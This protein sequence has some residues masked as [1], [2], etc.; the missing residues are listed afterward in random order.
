MNGQADHEAFARLILAIEP[1]LD[2]VVIIGGWAHR[3]YRLHPGAQVL[4][5]APL[6]TLDTD[7]ALPTKLAAAGQEVRERLFGRGFSEERLGG[8]NPPATHYVLGEVKSGFFAEFLTPLTGSAYQ[9][10][11][12]PKTTKRLGGVVAQRL[13]YLEILLAAP[14]RVDLDPSKGFPLPGQRT[15]QV[16]NPAA[17]LAHKIL[18]HKK[19]FS[20]KSAKDILYIHDTL[21]TFGGKLNDLHREWQGQ[22]RPLLH[23][24][25]VHKV[26]RGVRGLFGQ[27]N[28]SVR[29]AARIAGD[30]KLTP[31]S[32]REACHYGLE[33][34]FSQREC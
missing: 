29:E 6:M 9:R 18:I 21:E 14:W 30:R 11:G 23:K 28:D 1:W 22:V 2:D 7:V 10:Q 19:R 24:R 31:A 13:R 33:R 20:T 34:V 16:A 25:A 32:I 4:D 8:D 5:Y 15:V 17:F 27:I 3:L 12:K 26:V